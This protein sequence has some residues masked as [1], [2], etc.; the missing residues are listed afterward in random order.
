MVA[1]G[2]LGDRELAGGAAGDHV[3]LVRL[4]VGERNPDTGQAGAGFVERPAH[5][6]GGWRLGKGWIGKLQDGKD[7]DLKQ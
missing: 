4:D 3:F 6:C 2:K 1:G 5:N 7:T